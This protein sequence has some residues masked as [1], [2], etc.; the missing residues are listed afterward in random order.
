MKKPGKRR[1]TPGLVSKSLVGAATG[2][3]SPLDPLH[4]SFLFRGCFAR[5]LGD[6]LTVSF[7][8]GRLS[9]RFGAADA[10]GGVRWSAPREVQRAIDVRC[11]AGVPTPFDRRA[12]PKA[13]AP[14]AGVSVRFHGAVRYCRLV[15]PDGPALLVQGS[16]TSI[17]GLAGAARPF[18]TAE[19]VGSAV[20]DERR[21]KPRDSGVDP[22]GPHQPFP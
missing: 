12:Y 1:R 16:V 14:Q 7:P 19:L 15:L 13:P 4:R 2:R 22:S 21:A 18:D 6:V 20:S 9:A 8:A 11:A 10:R 3:R 5:V 17:T